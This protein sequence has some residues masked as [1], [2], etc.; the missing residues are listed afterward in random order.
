MMTVEREDLWA[1][2]NHW[3]RKQRGAWFCFG[4]NHLKRLQGWAW[5]S[6][7]WSPCDW[8]LY[9]ER[10]GQIP[11]ALPWQSLGMW[12]FGWWR[13]YN[14]GPKHERVP[15]SGKRDTLPAASLIFEAAPGILVY[16]RA[17]CF[18]CQLWDSSALRWLFWVI[19]SEESI[20][21][22]LWFL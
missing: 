2:H 20:C 16:S 19:V 17:M 21:L 10:R 7:A 8:T 15:S 4:E 1:D 13:K 5:T 9:K 12:T 11:F 6:L 14:Q 18:L 3:L 22:G